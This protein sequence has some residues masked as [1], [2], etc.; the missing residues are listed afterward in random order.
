MTEMKTVENDRDAGLFLHSIENPKR[1]EDSIKVALMMESLTGEP[2]RMWGESIVGFGRYRY[3]RADGSQHQWM[4]TGLSPRK[5]ALT[6]YIMP[7]FS[8]Y[9]D[10][11][12][13]LGK[14]R[15]S[16]SC[17]YLTRLANVNF[18]VLTELVRRSVDDMRQKYC[19]QDTEPVCT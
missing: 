12:A 3:R 16:V 17:L 13:N 2:P 15:H 8:K 5:A 11:L 9:G 19:G 18:D 1:K 7:G 4:L 14:H 10:L 6:I